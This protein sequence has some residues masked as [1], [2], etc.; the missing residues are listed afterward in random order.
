M[1]KRLQVAGFKAQVLNSWKAKDQFE[2]KRFTGPQ[3][4]D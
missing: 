1:N 3:V 4:R 2:T